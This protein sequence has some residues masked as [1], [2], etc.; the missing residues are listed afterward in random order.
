MCYKNI[1]I[2][3]IGNK[4]DLEEKREVSYEEGKNFAEENNLLFFE[5]SA[6]DGNNIQEIFFESAN[7]LVD[8]IE[9]GEINLEAPNTGIK[10]NNSDDEDDYNRINGRKKCC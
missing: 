7:F 9:N 6:K 4:T 10:I 2:C 8:K 1:L 3:L 5:T